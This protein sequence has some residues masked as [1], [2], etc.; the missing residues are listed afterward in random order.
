MDHLQRGRTINHSKKIQLTNGAWMM[1][2]TLAGILAHGLNTS[3]MQSNNKA[4]F[5]T[6][7]K[8]TT[9]N[10]QRKGNTFGYLRMKNL[11]QSNCSQQIGLSLWFHGPGFRW[12]SITDERVDS[13][14]VN[15]Y[16]STK[17]RK[18]LWI[19]TNEKFETVQLL[20]I[21]RFEAMIPWPR[22]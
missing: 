4:G 1:C 10:Q 20:S 11:R 7:N 14:Q 9:M 15:N 3:S 22:L 12:F 18:Y 5:S 19:F 2:Y 6:V 17:K 13:Q 8:S 16:E 21:D